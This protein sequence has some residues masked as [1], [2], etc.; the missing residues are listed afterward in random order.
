MSFDSSGYER[1][2][3]IHGGYY[4][5]HIRSTYVKIYSILFAI[6]SIFLYLFAEFNSFF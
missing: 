1:N 4:G 6:Y 2:N 3:Q 5:M